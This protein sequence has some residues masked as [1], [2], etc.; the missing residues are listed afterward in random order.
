MSSSSETRFL[1]DPDSDPVAIRIEGKAS[2][3]NCSCVKEFVE[4]AIA[5]GKRRFVMDFEGCSGM[6]STF[7]GLLAGTSL[8]LRK[9]EPRG[10]LVVCNLNERNA[11]LVRNLGLTRLLTVDDG[12]SAATSGAASGP[13][14]CKP[15]SDEVAAA[16]L[17]LDMHT[18]LVEADE[19]NAAKFRDVMDILKK[20]LGED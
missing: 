13:L 4:G 5:E 20:Q 16:R 8:Q 1:V 17:V 19:S 12:A 6:D 9:T 11:E 3:Q 10:S 14:E 18:N 7:L 15:V 2:F